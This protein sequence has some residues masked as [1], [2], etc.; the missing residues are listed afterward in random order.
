MFE[1]F[2]A[3]L[4]PMLVLFF[5]II[6]GFILNKKK[7]TPDNTA[8]VLSKLETNILLPAGVINGIAKN[9]TVKGL[10][11]NYISLVYSIIPLAVAVCIAII[12]SR[13]FSKDAN[14]R[15]IYKYA[16]TFGNF[17][18]VGQAIVP[19]ILGEDMY[20]GYL[21]YIMPLYAIV[22]TW[23]NA[24]LIPHGKG[25]REILKSIINPVCI[26]FVIG[27]FLGLTGLWNYT[28]KA[29]QTTVGN[30]SACMGPISMILTGFVIGD[31]DIIKLLKNTKVYVATLLRLVVLPA[32]FVFIIWLLG[33]S[34]ENMIL[35]LFAFGVPLGLNTIV[36]PAAYGGDAKTGASMAM[37]SHTLCVITIPLMYALLNA[38]F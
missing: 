7:I 30:L 26:S 36:Y 31:F 12:L 34:K 10:S 5:C 8:K 24:L 6:I 38:I 9:C 2:K 1:T 29:V 16:L 20:F 27:A 19:V 21:L 28:P 14:K 3:T 35:C 11:E 25:K 32:V 13:F 37:I 17:G 33:A 22:Y 4:S 18:F 23:G 15:N